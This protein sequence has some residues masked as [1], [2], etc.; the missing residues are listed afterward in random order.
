MPASSPSSIGD[1]QRA[2]ALGHASAAAEI[3]PILSCMTASDEELLA[4]VRRGDRGAMDELLT[5]YEAPVYRCAGACEAL[6]RTVS[7]CRRLPGGEVPPA[8]R[9]A[10]R[11]AIVALTS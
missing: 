11:H 4:A 6:K 1:E 3:A 5:R 8:V 2:G 9:A 10:V 7:L